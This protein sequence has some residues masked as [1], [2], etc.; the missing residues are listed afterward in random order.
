[1]FIHKSGHHEIKMKLIITIVSL[2]IY[3]PHNGIILNYKQADHNSKARGFPTIVSKV[4]FISCRNHQLA[5]SSFRRCI[6]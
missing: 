4:I 1:M 6:G 5:P 3:G 2:S